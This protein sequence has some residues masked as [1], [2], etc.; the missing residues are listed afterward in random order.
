MISEFITPESLDEALAV[1]KDGTPAFCYA[2]GTWINNSSGPEAEGRAVSLE[3]LGLDS[4]LSEEGRIH[5]GAMV[6]LQNLV[7]SAELPDA[8]REAAASLSLRNIRNAATIGGNV[9]VNAEDSCLVPVL[10]ALGAEIR[11]AASGVLTLEDYLAGTEAVRAGDLILSFIL[12][13]QLPV[14]SFRRLV[15]TKSSP[16]L[17]TVAVSLSMV[18]DVPSWKIFGAGI[19]GAASRL[20]ALDGD[21][22]KEPADRSELE[23]LAASVLDA[24]GDYRGSGEYKNRIGAVYIAECLLECM[25]KI[26]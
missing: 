16:A 24:S 21:I 1:L 18:E 12:P 2:G 9:A 26:K 3:K 11:T 6:S 20:T 25:E 4:I 13:A 15:R 5:I 14:C 7:D 8:L 22:P 10:L 23:K 17:I 19:N